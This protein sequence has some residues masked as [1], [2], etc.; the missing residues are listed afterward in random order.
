MARV[1]VPGLRIKQILVGLHEY[2]IERLKSIAYVA[3]RSRSEIIREA[4]DLWLRIYDKSKGGKIG[5]ETDSQS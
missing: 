4:V 2:Q 3:G 1:E 5:T